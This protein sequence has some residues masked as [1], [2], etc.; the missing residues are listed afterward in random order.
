MSDPVTL[1]PGAENAGPAIT[2]NDGCVGVTTVDALNNEAKAG[3]RLLLG[4]VENRLVPNSVVV[5][6]EFNRFMTKVFY[7]WTAGDP[8]MPP[9]E[10]RRRAAQADMACLIGILAQTCPASTRETKKTPSR[11]RG[12]AVATTPTAKPHRQQG[13]EVWLAVDFHKAHG[14]RFSFRDKKC[15]IISES[16]Q[17]HWYNVRSK[18]DGYYKAMK[19]HDLFYVRFVSNDFVR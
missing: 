1:Q 17:I 13:S 4:E 6:D 18:N 7:N 14:F 8:I 2:L 10:G 5:D 15:G 12:S 11:I 16:M 19:K 3:L 9:V